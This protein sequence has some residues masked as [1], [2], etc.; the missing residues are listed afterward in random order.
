MTSTI[1]STEQLCTVR[2]GQQ[3][4]RTNTNSCVLDQQ[5]LHLVGGLV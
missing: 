5:L 3:S 1:S 4:S 2:A